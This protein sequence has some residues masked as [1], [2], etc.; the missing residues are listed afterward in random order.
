[1]D[2]GDDVSEKRDF[3]EGVLGRD[4]DTDNMKTSDDTEGFDA[5]QEAS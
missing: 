1:M 2:L 4:V 5:D 3:I